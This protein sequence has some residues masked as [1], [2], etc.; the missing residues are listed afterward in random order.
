MRWIL[1]NRRQMAMLEPTHTPSYAEMLAG[2]VMIQ[3]RLAKEDGTRPMAIAKAMM[4]AAVL[5]DDELERI[6]KAAVKRMIG[7]THG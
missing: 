5:A 2:I 7:G 6:G 3:E 4:H 1:S